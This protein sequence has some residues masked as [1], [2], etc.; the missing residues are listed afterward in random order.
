M[1][2][3]PI[4]KLWLQNEVACLA[5]SSLRLCRIAPGEAPTIHTAT[6]LVL[7]PGAKQNLSFLSKCPNLF[8][9]PWSTQS[10]ETHVGSDV[11]VP[12]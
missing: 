9:C 11:N 6:W 1:P 12:G 3:A 2:F 7:C 4:G 10:F 5:R 8:D